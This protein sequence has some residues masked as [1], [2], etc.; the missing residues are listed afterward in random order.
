MSWTRLLACAALLLCASLAHAHKPSDSYLTLQIDDAAV[1]GHWD[2]ALRDLD[3]VLDLDRNRDS[4]IDWGE[5]RTRIGEIDAYAL[6]HL[7][8]SIDAGPCSLAATDPLI[9]RHSDGAYVVLTL[10][11]HCT[12][13]I[14]VLTVDYSLLFDVDAQHRGLLK[15]ET[16]GASA[17]DTQVVTA[18][19]AADGRRQAFAAGGTSAWHQ[20]KSFIGDGIGHIA[21]GFDHILFLIA[22]LLPAVLGR[23]G[24]SWFAVPGISVA[25]WNVAKTVT[26]FTLAHSITLSLA[27]LHFVQLPARLTESMI[28]LSVLV[29]AIDNLVPILPS[30]RWVVAFVFGLMHGFG[31]ASVLVDLNLPRSA[32]ALSLFGFNVG[33]EMGQLVLVAL[34]V[35]LAYLAREKRLYQLVALKGGSVVIALL[36][37]GWLIERSLNLKLMPF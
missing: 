34:L 33:V 8:L 7:R 16:K 25:L 19:F 6:A 14:D 22:L 32:L 11:G 24:R 20:L 10:S 18:V 30:K 13:R 36:A 31:F 9:D 5:V 4:R 23:S 1:N 15:L 21:G 12:G 35:P 17:A 27:T 2:I 37:L 3:V 28:A 26:A 29:T